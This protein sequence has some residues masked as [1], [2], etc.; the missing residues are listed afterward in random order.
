[1]NKDKIKNLKELRKIVVAAKKR[2]KRVV[3]TN[4]CFDIIH[5]GHIRYLEKTSSLG[6]KLV[7]ALNSDASERR[8]KGDR[9]PIIPAQERAA[10][11]A[12]FECVDYV[13]IF[14]ETTP[15]RLIK[16]LQ[17]DVLVKGGDWRKPD[18]VGKDFVESY[19][20]KVLSVGFVKGYSSS[21][22]IARIR[23]DP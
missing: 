7:V 21:S 3:F 1:M 6:N 8:L 15:L 10:I 18:I 2:G 20:C 5:L 12:A 23:R 16:T 19:G 17:P 11:V 9:R 14:A 13:I 4:G 22:I